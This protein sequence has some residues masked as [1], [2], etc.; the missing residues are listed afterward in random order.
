MHGADDNSGA[1]SGV[2]MWVSNGDGTFKL[3]KTF[4]AGFNRDNLGT[5][6]FG[7]DGLS[8]TFYVDANGDGVVDIVQATE[9]NGVTTGNFIYVYA[10]NGRGGFAKTPITTSGIASAPG[11][12]GFAGIDCCQQSYMADVDGD[13]DIDYVFSASDD[14]V[15]A[16]L[17]TGS[18]TF[19][20]TP[21]TTALT[22]ATAYH[23]SGVT[24][25]EVGFLVDV[26]G[27]GRAD[28]VMTSQYPSTTKVWLATSAG[29]FSSAPITTTGFAPTGAS[30]FTGKGGNETSAMIDVT[31]DGKVDFVHANE[32]GGANTVYVFAG[33]G[34]GGFATSFSSS[35]LTNP[36]GTF[37]YVIGEWA[38][39]YGQFVDVTGDGKADF[40]ASADWLGANSGIYVWTNTGTGTF[41]ATPIVSNVGSGNFQTGAD[42]TE[43]T[44][45]VKVFSTGTTFSA[46]G[47]PVST[48]APGGV[49][50]DM[51]LWL[52]AGDLTSVADGGKVGIWSD[53]TTGGESII[54]GIDYY[55]PTLN[56]TTSSKLINFN[57][58]LSFNGYIPHVLGTDHRL[59]NSNL[60]FYMTTVAMDERIYKTDLRAPLGGGTDGNYPAFDLQTDGISP[61]GWNPWMSNSIPA[62][63]TGGSALLYNGNTG[64]SN[65]Q[66]QVFALSSANA[67]S[68]T[69]YSADNIIS[70]VDSYSEATTLDAFQQPQI[71][72]GLFIGSS[73]GEYWLGKIPEVLV[74]TRQLTGAEQQRVNSYLA[75]KYGITLDQRTATDY[76]AS[77]GT[78]KFW[79][80]LTNTAYKNDIAAIGRDDASGL[81]QKQSQSVN[82][83]VQPIISLATIVGSNTANTGTFS[84]NKVF[85]AWAND[86][87]PHSYS[88][89]YAPATF[90]PAG[91]V[92]FY[93]MAT[94][95]R[96]QLT[97]AVG[98]V[99]VGIPASSFADRLLIS[100]T[101]AFIPG[102]GVTQEIALVPDGLGNLVTASAVTIPD[103][104]FFTFGAAEK[105][106]GGVVNGLRM[107]LKANTL[108]GSDGDK[109]ATWASS[110][111][112]APFSASQITVSQQPTLGASTSALVNFNQTVNFKRSALQYLYNTT[113]NLLPGTYATPGAPSFHFI[114][115][116]TDQDPA[117]VGA[118]WY[119][120]TNPRGI[121]GNG[122]A[123]NHPAMDMFKDLVTATGFR[124]Y[125][126][127][128]GWWGGSFETMY[129]GGGTNKLTAQPLAILPRILNQQP[130]IFGLGFTWSGGTVFSSLSSSFANAWVDGYKAT[131]TDQFF[132]NYLVS[133][134][135]YFTVGS[136]GGGEFW[137]GNVSEVINYT[138]ELSDAEMA[139]VNTYLAIKYGTTLGQ[140]GS[141]T[142]LVGSNVNSYSY[143]ATDGTVIWSPATNVGYAF[144]IAGIGQDNFEGLLQKQ[145]QSVNYGF[146]PAIGLGTVVA[147]NDANPATFTV[148][149]SYMVWGSNGS[150]TTYNL[151]YT[152]NSFT[153]SAPTYL[154]SRV[155]KVQETGTV[156][157]VMVSIPGSSTG[158]YLVVSSTGSFTTGTPTEYA[159]TSDGAG[160]LVATVD[161]INGQYFTFAKSVY[162]PGCIAGGPALWL[163]GDVGVA[164]NG[165]AVTG[166]ADQGYSGAS[167]VQ[168]VAANQPNY[169]GTSLTNF[170]PGVT[171]NNTGSAQWLR[172]IPGSPD[173]II[174][175]TN[176]ALYSVARLTSSGN[177]LLS[178]WD[179]DGNDPA[180]GITSANNAFFYTQN[181]SIHTSPF[182][183]TNN[184]PFFFGTSWQDDVT[185]NNASNT[186]TPE[187]RFNGLSANSLALYNVY[188]PTLTVG[189]GGRGTAMEEIF[190]IGR[191]TDYGGIT[192]DVLETIVFENPLTAAE[193]QRLESYFGVKYGMTL[194]FN[195]LSGSGTTIYDVSSYS[196]NITGIGREDC[197]QLLQKQSRSVNS[198]TRL[199]IGL[200]TT[201]AATNATNVGSFTANG[202]FL[203][204]G[205]NGGTGIS[206]VSST[207]SACPLPSP[208]SHYTN[209]AYKFTETGIVPATFIQFDASGYGFNPLYPLYMQVYSDA[210][211]TTLLASSPMSFSGGMAT[212]S[213]D[214]PANA[215]S[216]VRFAGN[217]TSLANICIAPK[218]QTFFWNN[219]YYGDKTKTIT[220]NYNL[221]NTLANPV[222]SVTV[223]D[224]TTDPNVLL[225]KPTVNWWPVYDGLGIFI[226]RYDDN[227][228]AQQNSVTTTKMKFF[229][230]SSLG[231]A[232]TSA[233]AANTVDFVL[234]DIDGYIG[235]KDVVKVYGKLGAAIIYPKIERNHNYPFW[236]YSA[237]TINNS[238]GTITAGF[239]PWDLTVLGDAYVSFD[240]PVEEVYVEYT[241]QNQ[242][243]FKVYNDLRI[244][245]VTVTCKV[246]TPRAPI[247]DNVYI[248]K[249]AT[250][251]V[252]KTGE[253]VV[254]KFTIQ[255]TECSNKVINFSDQLPGGLTWVDSTIT[256]ALNFAS[257]NAYGNGQQLTINSL[258][259]PPGTS[260]LYG[261][262]KGN[263]QGT[264]ANQVNYTVQGGSGATLL[265][266]DPSESGTT[267]QPTPL[268]LIQ[269]DPAAELTVTKAVNKITTGQNTVVT[270]S[271]TVA[272]GNSLSAVK[273]SFQDVLPG[274]LTFVPGSLS[275]LSGGYTSSTAVSAYGG[276]GNIS[277]RDLSVPANG[278]VTF[279]IQANV[280]S[281]TVG[282]VAGNVAMATPDPLSG[283][284]IAMVNS[285]VVSTTI[286]NP[287][288][289]TINSPLNNTQTSLNPTISGTATSGAQVVIL[290][291]GSTTLCTTT[292]VSGT[293][294]CPVSLTAGPQTL[295]AIASNANG[296]STPATV[297]FTAVAPP[298]VAIT[299]PLA[300]ASLSSSNPPIS[301][302]A[303]P[304]ASVTVAGGPG[305]T[306]GPCVTTATAGGSWTCT[307]LNFNSGPQTVTA[308]AGNVGGTSSPATVSFSVVAPL[309]V[310]T[311]PA[312]LTTTQNTPVSGSAAAAITPGGGT[313]P[314]TYSAFN[315]TSG[316]ATSATAISTPH[317]TATINP[318]T[319]VYSYTPTPG[320]S[321]TDAIGIK[322]CDA[323][324]VCVSSIIP[325]NIAGPASGSGTLDCSTAQI[326]G[327]VAGTPGNGVLKLTIA[328]STTGVMPVTVSGSGISASPS[329]YVINATATGTQ[330]FYVPITYSG[331][332]FGPTTIT[333]G[334]AGVC[335]PDLSLVTPKTV[336]T[337]VLN[338][339]PACAPATAATLIK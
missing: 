78:T 226:P 114:T 133:N 171:F 16:Y 319:G 131:T 84:G 128:P 217:T 57:P 254:Y 289:V 206:P 311:T 329:P 244:G 182:T 62:E 202:A 228:A 184:A 333:V 296:T 42:F 82:I 5:E 175:R 93:R 230:Q 238:T 227:S 285:N 292:A 260:Y 250:P 265:S 248:Y 3:N 117:T 21:I 51:M 218:P 153:S 290:G 70:S 36:P 255:N 304:G 72:G 234:R 46:N 273:T 284:R 17:N 312:A 38:G 286:S 45:I 190:R 73:G 47:H 291:P 121:M 101:A 31:G 251:S 144:D 59:H 103:G 193:K 220:S 179:D 50:A 150:G 99:F 178:G 258:T 14:N 68:T 97:G 247:A 172:S 80:A 187:M 271:F 1:G 39:E 277:L 142:A 168:N 151:A 129:N 215:T 262:V 11:F 275:G 186:I 322:V 116:G 317:G 89:V 314:L 241:K 122:D 174:D 118:P 76:V 6:V 282:A 221:N 124:P 7:D 256:T 321:G 309:T 41:N 164:L 300:N 213:Y 170:N 165:S 328:V 96:M 272:S 183:I 334:G 22:G 283:F 308:T 152:P 192:G 287:P 194:P 324:T 94:T 294:A 37:N 160:N 327:I 95:W 8:A 338:L 54:Q 209:L 29:S 239:Y 203:I 231:V 313:Q 98:N 268:T 2:S 48:T 259:V 325:I 245:A 331:A 302:T 264:Y 56:S 40:V 49:S 263:T 326:T 147:S 298:T 79:N 261:T 155:W 306:G 216:Y 9:F 140:G 205:A 106:P 240:S 13:G 198:S 276:V 210:G 180:L 27:D 310:N 135:P 162:S 316:S 173:K 113:Q 188:V 293:Y 280:N 107:W 237:L 92:G 177:A 132:N 90:T 67:S 303:T 337:S 87:K 148:D 19:A 281:Y 199:T 126:S 274:E 127:T 195:Y 297:S 323:L 225:Y 83:Q 12:Y 156:G 224:G 43:T 149:K 111:L 75:T 191:D 196:A 125:S 110:V 85:G 52:R 34:A 23:T 159:M 60:P 335:S 15:S 20:T 214:F 336:S 26:N 137:N 201:I 71:G 189:V 166:W 91:G 104:A 330:T 18:G 65:R 61:N 233:V 105:A 25:D 318:A 69:N 301:G 63:W 307:S 332:A 212:T 169:T 229:S 108:T 145:S 232:S 299:S 279:S 197:Q 235:G 161:L 243:G 35:V 32:F 185:G 130:Q 246:P 181:S 136:S 30:V 288:S 123:G 139:K 222:M 143:V 305:S 176:G 211:F 207:T 77:D 88:I 154:M 267:F 86:G 120:S 100:N 102:I 58:S 119:G 266:D 109:V 44:A 320:Y 141:S 249:Q 236:D 219:W 64:G 252:Q 112:S 253:P 200:S 55:R 74:Y 33:N 269:N 257:I 53:A 339:G 115:V 163:K 223:T 146:Q 242:Y 134:V 4:D 24:T 278:S 66:P 315:P 270:Y 204:A 157:T 295:S 28:L 167:L 208:I 138:R 158:T 10:G 81:L